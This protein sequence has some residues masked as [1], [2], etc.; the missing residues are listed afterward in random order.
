MR[1]FTASEIQTAPT[2]R[3]ATCKATD[4]AA[5]RHVRC[6]SFADSATS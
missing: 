5:H 3:W 1:E 2:G 6:S 4:A